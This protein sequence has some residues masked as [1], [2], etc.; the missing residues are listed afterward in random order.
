MSFS[1][2]ATMRKTVH[3]LPR[4]HLLSFS[5]PPSRGAPRFF[6]VSVPPPSWP[7]ACLPACPPCGALYNPCK[8]GA[9]LLRFCLGL[10]LLAACAH[11][12]VFSLCAGLFFLASHVSLSVILIRH[13]TT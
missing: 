8:N 3:C 13:D 12:P 7:A 6:L 4:D 9:L 5:L 1:S 11:P 2:V 10:L